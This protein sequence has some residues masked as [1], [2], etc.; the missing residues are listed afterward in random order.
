[1]DRFSSLFD[2]FVGNISRHLHSTVLHINPLVALARL[3]EGV[4]SA[5]TAFGVKVQ[6]ARRAADSK[7]GPHDSCQ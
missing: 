4:R 7:A 2:F 1:M 3:F 6:G 5:G